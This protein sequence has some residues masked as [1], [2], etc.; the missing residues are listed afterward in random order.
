MS[1]IGSKRKPSHLKVPVQKRQNAKDRNN[2]FE[3]PPQER[4]SMTDLAIN[5]VQSVR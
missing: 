4:R 5:V 2:H 1:V 3:F